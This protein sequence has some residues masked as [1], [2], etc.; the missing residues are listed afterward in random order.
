MT[1]SICRRSRK[2]LTTQP[3]RKRKRTQKSLSYRFIV[4]E[5]QYAWISDCGSWYVVKYNA[6][7]DATR[8]ISITTL[9]CV[10]APHSIWELILLFVPVFSA[11]HTWRFHMKFLALRPLYSQIHLGWHVAGG[12]ILPR[13]R[14]VPHHDWLDTLSRGIDQSV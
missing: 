12:Y 9:S 11:A 1:H 10:E 8:C 13:R 3:A 14:K 4:T 6:L 5:W 7:E 2:K